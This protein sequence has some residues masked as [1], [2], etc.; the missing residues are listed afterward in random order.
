M[1]RSKILILIFAFCVLNFFTGCAKEGRVDKAAKDRIAAGKKYISQNKIEEAVKEFEQAAASEPGNPEAH[2]ELGIAYYKNRNFKKAEDSLKSALV[3]NPADP[4]IHNSLGL[5]F[6][7][8]GLFE[9]AKRSF[10]EATRLNKKFEE[11]RLNLLNIETARE[12]YNFYKFALNFI[13]VLSKEYSNGNNSFLRGANE[14]K[15]ARNEF[16]NITRYDVSSEVYLAKEY[17]DKCSRLLEEA[18]DK[19]QAKGPQ[20]II[21]RFSQAIQQRQEAID[22]EIEGYAMSGTYAGEFER[23]KAK[24]KIA[25]SYYVDSARKLEALM[26]DR[27]ALFDEKNFEDLKSLLDYYSQEKTKEFGPIK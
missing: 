11:A 22:L 14:T 23:S 20:D 7:R 12:E 19:V 10:Q 18:S 4:K 26:L 2:Y 24:V 16:G 9:D 21:D 5:A 15:A 27:P 13:S 25:D 6:E 1:K 17:F 3:L 8:Q